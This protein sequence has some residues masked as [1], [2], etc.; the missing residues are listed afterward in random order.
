MTK[1]PSARRLSPEDVEAHYRRSP[2][3][4]EICV[5]ALRGEQLCAVVVPDFDRLRA[6]RVANA[7]EAI[8]YE[9]DN[10]GRELPADRRVCDYVLRAEPLPRAATPELR[11]LE[12]Q[13]QLEAHGARARQPRAAPPLTEADR[14]LLD[15]PAGRAVV[16]ALER[17]AG[18]AAALHPALNLEIDLG[19]D[20]LARAE[21]LLGVERAIGAEFDP[22]EAAAALTVGEL[23]ALAGSQQARGP[24]PAGPDLSWGD[25]L[26]RAPADLPELR[27][28]LR[29]HPV[30][31]MVV[32][33]LLRAVFLAARVLLRLEVSGLE[34]VTRLERPFLV[35]PNH[36]SYL[37]PVIIC[38]TYPRALLPHVFH[39][40]ARDYFLNPFMAR[41]SRWLNILPVDPD[42]T[43][44]RALQASAA[45]LRAG[46]VLHIYP[47]GQRS[48]DGRLHEFKG[49]PAVL[50]TGLGLPIV[51]AAID[52]MHRVWARGERRVRP[53]K[54]RIRFGPPL[55]ARGRSANEVTEELKG[56]IARM[57]AEMRK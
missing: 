47:E 50:A 39:V 16:A 36:Q 27:P 31:V 18:P 4:S 57:L 21:A 23:I 32:T 11:R 12:L 17:Q 56:R 51:P 53:A 46:K 30:R 22:R 15:S 41:L 29:P 9:L 1:L 37:D 33:T 19:L 28:L 26:S 24:A 44:L 43:L 7:R 40:G 13:R 10:L 49:G 54:V 35:C 14:A 55:T 42:L 48:F 38:S 8:R 5:L 34:H 3:V 20:S 25:I 52:G 6:R 2:L 45:A